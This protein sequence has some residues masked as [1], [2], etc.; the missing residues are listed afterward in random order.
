M[1]NLNDLLQRAS[2]GALRAASPQ[3]Y[4][5]LAF[6]VLLLLLIAAAGGFY[7]G[8]GFEAERAARTIAQY[9]RDM[10]SAKAQAEANARKLLEEE[11]KRGNELARDLAQKN[12]E[13]QQ[14]KG[15]LT[16]A[17]QKATTGRACLNDRTLRLLDNAPGIR[18]S[19]GR[20]PASA[21]SPDAAPPRSTTADPSQLEST[22]GKNGLEAFESSDDDIARWAIEA[23]ALYKI[24]IDAR[25]AL[26]EF[27][28]GRREGTQP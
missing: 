26:I 19:R 7:T 2:G 21:R 28:R 14:L 18:P 4:G 24:C 5:W 20:V 17:L 9:E 3:V 11:T 12:H 22:P 6:T 1:M 8:K 16:N 10:V 25:D 13:T 27:E 23:G 15:A